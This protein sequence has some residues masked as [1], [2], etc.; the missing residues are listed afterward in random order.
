MNVG[1]VGQPRDGDPRVSY[2]IYE[3][4]ARKIRFR[5]LEYDIAAAQ[6]RIR[7]AGLPDRLAER[8]GLGQ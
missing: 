7:M 2:V 3:P 6:E 1:S 4:Q 8:L 5:R